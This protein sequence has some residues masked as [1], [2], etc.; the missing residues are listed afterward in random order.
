MSF[1][2]QKK[3]A[4]EEKHSRQVKFL[5]NTLFADFLFQ[6]QGQGDTATTPLEN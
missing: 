4:A 2:V 6:Q 5:A 3:H 1:H